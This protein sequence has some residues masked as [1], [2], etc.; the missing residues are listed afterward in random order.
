MDT[1]RPRHGF[2]LIEMTISVALGTLIVLVASAGFRVASQTVT[3]ANRLSQQN[4]MLRTA[5]V[6][7]NEEM[8]FWESFD[9]RSD[10]AKQVLR[11]ATYPFA[12]MDF[13]NPDTVLDFNPAHPRLWWSGELW[14]A[15]RLSDGTNYQRRFGDYSLFGRQGL[16]T[17][18][19]IPSYHN[20]VVGYG[21]LDLVSDRTWRHNIVPY[22]SNNLGYM[23][24]FDYL[25]ANF[26]YGFFDS[27]GDMPIEFGQPG[28]G[29]GR[30]R[31]S[32]HGGNKPL[33]KVE[34]GHDNGY[35]LTNTTGVS[36]YPNTHPNS[37]RASYNDN[38]GTWTDTLYPDRF[39][40]FP[41]V[42]F[43]NT[44]PPMWPTVRM[45]VKVCYQWMDFRHQVLISQLD[46]FTGNSTSMVLHGMTTTLRGARRQRG[47]DQE[48]TD[49]RYP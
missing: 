31:N 9:S 49:T 18:D 5:V 22:L 45:Q 23:A 42:S 8:D 13:R 4:S 48:P 24:A 41:V 21:T 29:P 7:A 46:P 32:W 27:S 44:L 30:F 14:S 16:T 28:V 25:P 26:V 39:N 19:T 36:G 17:Y 10:P 20:P 15:N 47:L 38:G 2:T 40:A 3:M 34:A 43:A 6:A 11:G 1:T 35:I 12:P 37:H 33:Q